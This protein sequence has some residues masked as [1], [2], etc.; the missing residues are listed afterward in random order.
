MARRA[1]SRE[2]CADDK[3]SAA[4]ECSAGAPGRNR[5]ASRPPRLRRCPDRLPAHDGRSAG[6][7]RRGP[8]RTAPPLGSGAA[9]IEAADP[10]QRDRAGAHRAGLQRH[11]QVAAVEPRS[12]RAPRRGGAH[13][14]HLGMGGGIV[15]RRASGCAPMRERSRRRASPPRRPAPRRRAPPPRASSSARRIGSGRGS[16]RGLLSR[17]AA[18]RLG[19]AYFA[20]PLPTRPSAPDLRSPSS[21]VGTW[22]LVVVGADLDRLHLQVI[23]RR[24]GRWRLRLRLIDAGQTR[25]M[26][27]RIASAI[28]QEEGANHVRSFTRRMFD[29]VNERHRVKSVAP[30]QRLRVTAPTVDESRRHSYPRHLSGRPCGLLIPGR[31]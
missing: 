20:V 30:P 8:W 10:R 3:G 11:P 14:H 6:A 26:T 24:P 22:T 19:D 25:T 29:R 27:M 23:F 1:S 7:N 17:A 16:H 4:S 2:G 21:T 28:E 13:R 31:N 5:A 18:L 12:R 9:E 15:V